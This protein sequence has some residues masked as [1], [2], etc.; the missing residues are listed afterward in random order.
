MFHGTVKNPYYHPS[1][2]TVGLKRMILAT[3]GVLPRKVYAA[4]FDVAFLGYRAILRWGYG[5]RIPLA[6]LSAERT[7]GARAAAVF[8]VMPFSL[9]GSAG[10]EA[11]YNAAIALET[12]GIT[13][14]FVECGVAQGGCAALMA[15]LAMSAGDT[16]A[17]W[18]FDSFEGLPEPTKEDFDGGATG[19]HLREL[20]RGSC[21]GTEEEVSH[22]LFNRFRLSRARI[23]LVKGWFDQTIPKISPILGPIALL[24][25]DADWYESVKCCLGN[26][27][28]NV[29]PG[30]QIIIDDYGSCFGARRAVDEF[31]ALHGL[32]PQLIPDGRGGII[33]TKL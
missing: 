10:L 20:P 21:L 4:I 28:P 3:K 11:T 26:L 2:V 31:L 23:T 30:G 18:L 7:R 12:A 24:R 17:I 5:I 9:V 33:F 25:I 16:R 14:S 22:L 6:F 13:G 19:T 32:A 27:Y 29:V 1:V 15:S 8:R